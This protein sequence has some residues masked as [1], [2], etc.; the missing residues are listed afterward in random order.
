M[1]SILSI[2]LY[3]W[4]F[5]AGTMKEW[6]N[7]SQY[8]YKLGNAFSNRQ[9]HLIE[10]PSPELLSAENPY[11]HKDR[12]KIPVL[13]DALFY[14]G[15]YF[16]YWG[17][18]P[19]LIVAALQP[20]SPEIIQDSA[21]VMGFM[22]GLLAFSVLL[23][24]A[25]WQRFEWLPKKIFVGGLFALTLNA[26][27]IW[28]LTRPKVYEAAI[29]GGQFFLF[30]GLFWAFTGLRRT[31]ISKWRLVLAGIFFG[32]AANTRVN[33]ALVIA[34]VGILV[35]WQIFFLN[36]W[37][38]WPSVSSSL[39]FGIPLLIGAGGLMWYN[40]ARFGSPLDFGYHFLITGPTIPEDPSNISSF[41]YIVPNIY[42]YLLRPPEV[43]NEFP[44]IIVPWIKNDMWP[45]LIKLPRNY[46]YTEPVASLLLTVPVI[47]LA[48]LAAFRLGWLYLIGMAPPR[49]SISVDDRVLF[50]WLLLALSGSV[51]FALIV[52]FVF[53]QNSYRYIVDITP[54]AILLG[55]LFLAQFQQ[56][57]SDRFVE[58]WLW[59]MSWRVVILLT[60]VFGILIAMKGYARAF[61]NQNP[62]LFYKLLNWLP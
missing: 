1:V 41:R 22:L 17:P 40:Y 10:K 29:V 25:I 21:L 19:G 49:L 30:G 38:W 47:G 31:P 4:V 15:K 46:F 50:R 8:F 11:F 34:F 53:I 28:S 43:R 9:L 18:I 14:E 16:L 26:P 48:V 7:G 60:P 61:E 44:Y 56:R 42:Q 3:L 51:F 54:T 62:D 32:V 24:R 6:P 45:V 37:D 27:L 35:L 12:G 36:K 33:L 58:G 52:L 39:L 23:L 59:R 55:I 20:L 57:I 13:W 5:T 2:F